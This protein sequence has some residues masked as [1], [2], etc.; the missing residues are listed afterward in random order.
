[1]EME[2]SYASKGVAG[3]ALGLGIGGLSLAVLNGGL[4]NILGNGN[5]N[6]GGA[7]CSEDRY[8][9]RYE[10]Q[11]N[12]KIAALETEVKFRDSQIFTDGK[13]NEFRNYVDGRFAIVN[14]KINDLTCGQAVINQKVTD[15]LAFIDSK[16][17]S[18][19]KEIY[20]YVN[21]TFVPGKLVMPL[22]SICPKAMPLC[23]E[24]AEKRK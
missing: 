18:T 2:K 24:F 11:Q 6:G 9:N 21:A 8:V 7:V 10:A 17:D 23:E 1:M 3:T 20:C 16:I 14:D 22:D 15:N 4:G 19:A 5:M 13:L 12:A